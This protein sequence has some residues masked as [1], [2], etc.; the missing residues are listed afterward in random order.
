MGGPR[1][2]TSRQTFSA[3]L[4]ETEER[5]WATAIEEAEPGVAAVAAVIR[6]GGQAVGTV[7]IAGPIH[8]FSSLVLPQLAEQVRATA[9]EL[10]ELWPYRIASP[11]PQANASNKSQ[12]IG[13]II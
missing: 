2:I 12:I 7:S 11:A 3:A 9:Q 8:R 6:V 13:N 10:S 1:A 5:G 4:D